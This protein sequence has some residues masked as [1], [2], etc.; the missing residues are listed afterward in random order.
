MLKWDNAWSEPFHLSFGVRQGSVLSPYRFAL[1]FLDDLTTTC[2]SVPVVCIILYADDILLI[3][4]SVYGL[5]TLVK[6]CE[7]DLD[8]LHMIVNTRKS[9]HF[10]RI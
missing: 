10:L 7:S 9:R 1:Y 8:K 5:D 6:I 3:A 4:P 2:V